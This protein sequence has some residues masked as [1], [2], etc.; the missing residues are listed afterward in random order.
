MRDTLDSCSKLPSND[1][2]LGASAVSFFFTTNYPKDMLDIGILYRKGRMPIVIP[3]EP[4]TE[5]DLKEVLKF[6]I[7]RVMPEESKFD[8]ENYDFSKILDK[9]KLSEEKGC[10]SNDRIREAMD[11]IRRGYDRNPKNDFITY[12]EESILDDKCRTLKRRDIS[13]KVYEQYYDDFETI[14]E[15]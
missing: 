5:D 9:L 12:L 7:K 6:H 11:E 2:I 8:L 14:G 10:Y 4:A 13:P 1:G 3:V 15:G